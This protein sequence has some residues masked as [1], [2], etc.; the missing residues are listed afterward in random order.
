M[1]D[2]ET[3]LEELEVKNKHKITLF[4]IISFLI[5][6][7]STSALNVQAKDDA[8][9][10][11]EEEFFNLLAQQIYDRKLYKYYDLE[12]SLQASMIGSQFLD[13]F[14]YHYNPDAP[15][16]SGCYLVYYL[17][18]I[19]YEYYKDYSTGVKMMISFPYP[20]GSMDRHFE[21]M[22]AL[23]KNLKGDTDYDTV[24]NVH[25]YLIDNFEYDQR[26]SMENHTDI[27]GFKDGVMVCSGYGLATYY[28]LNEAGI[29]TRIIIGND[30][31]HMWN[32]VE[33]DGKWYNLDVTWDDEGSN[34]R[35]YKYFLKSDADFPD[36]QRSD[37]YN[38]NNFNI[39]IANKSYNSNIIDTKILFVIILLFVNVYIGI[40]IMKNKKKKSNTAIPH[41]VV[42]NDGFDDWLKEQEENFN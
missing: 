18:S 10:K 30:E 20:K 1:D 42:V 23:A 40:T 37:K 26:S 21:H 12:K 39:E 17:N 13:D 9:I 34:G 38:I 6:C 41:G 4:L 25:N 24:L 31:S 8:K 27:D 35:S 15:L 22:S 2:K 11:S 5:A 32:M 7:F 3:R 19:H 33:L 28:L 16:K 29:K 14:S 36:H